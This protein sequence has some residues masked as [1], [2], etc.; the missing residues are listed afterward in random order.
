MTTEEEQILREKIFEIICDTVEVDV[1][2]WG[3]YGGFK[4]ETRRSAAD[5][6]VDLIKKQKIQAT[7]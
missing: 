3:E 7:K 6:I 2:C 4:N 5:Q 1:S